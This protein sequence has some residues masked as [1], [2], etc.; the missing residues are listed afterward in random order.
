MANFFYRNVRARDLLDAFL[1]SSISSLLLV[2]FYL[3]VTDYPQLGGGSL[4]IA[5]MLY[6]GLLMMA[7]IVLSL[8]FLGIRARWATAI[9]GGV[10]F[11]V[12][13]DELGKFI[14]EDNNYFFRPTVGLIYAVFVLLYLCFNFL[15]RAQRLT[16]REYQ[17]NALVELEEAIAQ[18]LDQSERAHIY[19][20]LDASDKNSAMTRHLREFV[21]N[22]KITAHVRPGRIRLLL[23]KVDS[24]YRRFWEKRS[25][26]ALVRIIFIAEII[27]LTSGVIYT[28]YDNVG[29]IEAVL[30]GSLTY[31]SELI[32]GQVVAS[33]VAGGFVLYGLSRLASS[34]YEAFEQFRRATLINIYLTQVF[35]FIRIQFEALP[36]LLINLALLLLIIF[37][38]RQERRLGDTDAVR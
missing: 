7:A 11:G 25:S 14:T 27:V 8:L 21:E 16:S 32:I 1:V 19:K 3:F 9:I 10:G 34:R 29:D 26:N 36:G 28:I 38:L 33:V 12:F 13:I 17:L 24:A 22:I 31:G 18:D 30:G 5:H 2:R 4:H 6:G 35:I 23:R 37:V 15:T 20:L